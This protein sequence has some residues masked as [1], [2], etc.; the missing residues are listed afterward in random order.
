VATKFR[1]GE[2][3]DIA[4][5]AAE[6]GCHMPGVA[7]QAHAQILRQIRGAKDGVVALRKATKVKTGYMGFELVET[8]LADCHAAIADERDQARIVTMLKRAAGAL[9]VFGGGDA[10]PSVDHVREV[11]RRLWEELEPMT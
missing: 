11:L 3:E 1:G 4:F 7:D 2:E 5:A 9:G 6:K 10:A 8:T